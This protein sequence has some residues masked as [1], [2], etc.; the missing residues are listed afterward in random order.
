MEV[1]VI[2][3]A[4]DTGQERKVLSVKY[5]AI[6]TQVADTFVCS[7]Y[8]VPQRN[9]ADGDAGRVTID[10]VAGGASSFSVLM[11]PGWRFSFTSAQCWF[12]EFMNSP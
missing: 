12:D 4:P 1:E 3:S 5:S 10:A 6:T 8:D 9:I 2:K 7:A 11:G